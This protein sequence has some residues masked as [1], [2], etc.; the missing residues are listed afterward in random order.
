MSISGKKPPRNLNPKCVDSNGEIHQ[1]EIKEEQPL[2][3]FINRESKMA[4]SL[5]KR[6]LN[7]LKN[8]LT[9][10]FG[11]ED[12]LITEMFISCIINR[13]A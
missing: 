1:N 5:H 2:F 6:N 10:F 12:F 3:E 9:P 11:Q 13:C 4:S 7:H 8:L